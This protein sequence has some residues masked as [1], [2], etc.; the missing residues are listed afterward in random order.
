MLSV[1]CLLL[2]STGFIRIELKLNDHDQKL[3]AV[4][5]VISKLKQ[6]MAENQLIKG[7]ANRHHLQT[8][9]GLYFLAAVYNSVYDYVFHKSDVFF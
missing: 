5:E 4:E 3:L 9:S 1:F 2:Y 7:T 6:G 8:L